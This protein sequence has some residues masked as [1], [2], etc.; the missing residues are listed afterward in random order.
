MRDS[1][2]GK[3]FKKHCLILVRV[4]SSDVG[5]R[6]KSGGLGNMVDLEVKFRDYLLYYAGAV[7][8]FGSFPVATACRHPK[9]AIF[10]HKQKCFSFSSLKLYRDGINNE[11]SEIP[12]QRY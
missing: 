5:M 12:K 1:L 9:G 6:P 10:V 4:A 11:Y 8:L 7:I 3:L 2:K